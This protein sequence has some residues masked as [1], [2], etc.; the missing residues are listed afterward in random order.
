MK[1][2]SLVLII[3]IMLA[4]YSLTAQVSI[5]TDGSSPDVSA[6]MD[7]KSDTAGILIPRMTQA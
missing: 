7:V 4:S 1:S 3:I 2:Q 6:M 5:N